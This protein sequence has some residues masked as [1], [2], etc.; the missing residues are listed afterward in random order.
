MFFKCTVE[1]ETFASFLKS[2]KLADTNILP[3][4]KYNFWRTAATVLQ[5]W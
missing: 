4:K 1:A 2:N 3:N 5:P